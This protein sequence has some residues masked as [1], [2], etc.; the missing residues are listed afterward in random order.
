[1]AHMVADVLHAVKT[2]ADAVGEPMTLGGILAACLV[3]ILTWLAASTLRL[4]RTSASVACPIR[5]GPT[6]A[7]RAAVPRAPSLAQLCVL[8]T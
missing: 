1:M 4:Q 8:R 7:T 5:A 6:R 3:A 2:T